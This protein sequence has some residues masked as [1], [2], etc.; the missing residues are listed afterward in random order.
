MGRR[1][2]VS[3]REIVN[4]ILYV[5]RTG[6][7]WRNLP[8]D[9]PHWNTVYSCFHRWT[10]NGVLDKLYTA[11]HREV[12]TLHGKK[13]TP[14]L[15]IVDSQSVKVTAKRGHSCLLQRGWDGGKKINGRKRFVVVDSLGYWIEVCG[16]AR[17]RART[18]RSR[19][20]V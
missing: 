6:C 10:W 13:E 8:H 4:A 20:V 18:R 7:Q 5:A 19:G 14:T 11:L 17:Q 15:G 9:F 3:R 12:R 16:A 1:A 2:S